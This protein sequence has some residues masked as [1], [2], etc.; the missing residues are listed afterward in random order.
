MDVLDLIADDREVAGLD[1]DCRPE[2]EVGM[3]CP[4]LECGP[5]TYR[6]INTFWAHWKKFHRE[7]VRWFNCQE[8]GFGNVEKGS[9]RRLK[10]NV[11]TC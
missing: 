6:S 1:D 3:A 9:V 8:C 10:Y 5:K 2:F 4:V 11:R 7:S